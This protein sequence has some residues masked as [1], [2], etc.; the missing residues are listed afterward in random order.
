MSAHPIWSSTKQWHKVWAWERTFC[1]GYWRSFGKAWKWWYSGYGFY[2]YDR[3]Q[4]CGLPDADHVLLSGNG[5]G[6]YDFAEFIKDV[7]VGNRSLSWFLFYW[8]IWNFC[9]RME[10]MHMMSLLISVCL[11]SEGGISEVAAKKVYA[12]LSSQVLWGLS[13]ICFYVQQ[14]SRLDF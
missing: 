10:E 14:R 2:P 13:R 3:K 5:L 9:S 7:F 1:S 4:F 8:I 6:N 12:S 11:R